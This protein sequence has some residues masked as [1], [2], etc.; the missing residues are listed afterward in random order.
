MSK[1]AVIP[2]CVVVVLDAAR[3]VTRP[4]L[5][6]GSLLLSTRPSA[7]RAA[8]VI[9]VPC[10]GWPLLLPLELRGEG[11]QVQWPVQL[12]GKLAHW[13]FL[14]AVTS[15]RL[16]HVLDQISNSRF[17]VDTGASYSIS[18]SLVSTFSAITDFL[19]TQ[20]RTSSSQPSRHRPQYSVCCLVEGFFAGV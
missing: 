13:G 17:L 3:G 15:G 10:P 18:L 12:G 14:N 9:A 5:L 6:L 19:W 8:A 7:I 11:H 1:E 2:N 20:Q 16:V 4:L